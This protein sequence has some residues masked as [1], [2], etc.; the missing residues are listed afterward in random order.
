MKVNSQKPFFQLMPA[1]MLVAISGILVEV[2]VVC[3]D[4][5]VPV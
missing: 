4:A 2:V 3:T 1:L 5:E